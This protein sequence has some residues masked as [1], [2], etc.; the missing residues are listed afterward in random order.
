MSDFSEIKAAQI[1][2]FL[3]KLNNGRENYTKLIKLVYLAD[4][5][6]ILEWGFPITFDDMCS[7]PNGPVVS[8]FLNLIKNENSGKTWREFIKKDGY[9]VILINEPGD[10]ELSVAEKELLQQIYNKYKDKNYSDMI[11]F[12]HSLPEYKDPGTSSIPI[13]Y[14][15]ILLAS[16]MPVYKVNEII[17]NIKFM[18]VSNSLI[19][20]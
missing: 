12:T 5:K 3:I 6:A 10:D 17:E 1:A 18:L 9:N 11:T 2:A 13:H 8:R 15:D 16:G 7:L 14:E 19:N 4:R 20:K